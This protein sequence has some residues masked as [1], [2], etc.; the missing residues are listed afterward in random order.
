MSELEKLKKCITESSSIAL[1][2]HLNA[3]P[4][5]ITSIV[6][7][8]AL[9]RT[10]KKGIKV[11]QVAPE[12]INEVSSRIISKF[13]ENF[14]TNLE[15]DKMDM[16]ALV[17]TSS[18]ILLGELESEFKTYR[19]RILIVDHHNPSIHLPKE[20]LKFIDENACSTCEIVLGLYNVLDVK[21]KR[22]IARL[23][24]T[25][26]AYDT[27]HFKIGSKGTFEAVIQLLNLGADLEESISLLRSKAERPEK[28]AR[29]KAASRCR[30][31]E[32][33]SWII[34]ISEVSSYQASAARSLVNIGADL[35][36][37]YGS[38]KGVLRINLRA[39]NAFKEACGHLGRDIAAPMGEMLGG[40][41]GGHDAAAGINVR[42]WKGEP[43]NVFRALK[44]A[45]K[46]LPRPLT[47]KEIE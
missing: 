3:D 30:I 25:G 45:L 40:A 31:F 35:A 26:I 38:S 9:L 39:T 33:E 36:V 46:V 22:R 11:K 21:P 18:P 37:V 47:L 19:G 27:G 8:K 16:V 7:L 2:S 29:L 17:D 23:M 32:S 4:D 20:S 12:G 42:K 24:L 10:L 5:S 15:I 13:K 44:N 6:S 28:I 1:I 41:G 43:S 14:E 34:V